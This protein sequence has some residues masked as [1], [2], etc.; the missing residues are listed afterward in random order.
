MRPLVYDFGQLDDSTENDYTKQMVHDRCSTVVD[1]NKA[2]C[3]NAVADV[4][5]WSQSY[6]KK[7]TVSNYM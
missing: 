3:I 5:T 2:N 7:R 1:L 4:L 6:M